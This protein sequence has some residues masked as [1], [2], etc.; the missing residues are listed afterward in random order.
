RS[1]YLDESS[2]EARSC[3][4]IVFVMDSS[5]S[6]AR[7]AAPSLAV[8]F[9]SRVVK[10][11]HPGGCR[12]RPLRPSDP[13]R[14][15]RQVR[16]WDAPGVMV[17]TDKEA[18]KSWDDAKKS[19]LVAQIVSGK[20]SVKAA[21]QRHDL[22]A[23]TIQD[24]VRVFRRTTLRALDEHLRQTFLIQGADAASLSTAEY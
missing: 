21:C 3:F 19:A 6:L 10:T 17:G 7:G 13:G 18:W 15:S 14:V 12:H 2:D 16:G 5:Q 1:G 8:R 24:W 9:A 22:S 23:D 4:V 20:L 11:R